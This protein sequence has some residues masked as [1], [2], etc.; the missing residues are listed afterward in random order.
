MIRN[1]VSNALP[2]LFVRN[3]KDNKEEELIFCD[4]KVYSPGV[5]EM[6]KDRNTDNV[7]ISYS[8][9]KTN[10]KTYIYNVKTKEKKLVK[11]QIIPSGHDPENY[12]T[13]RLECKSHDGRL[14]PLTITRHKKTKLD[15][16]ANVLL[17]GYSSYGSTNSNSF[18]NL[19]FGMELL[20]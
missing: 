9:P 12:I 8:S 11:E 7:Y 14:I 16:S 13:E 20:V 5:A 6:Q 18:S 10:A 17:Y 19:F 2:K 1:E 4:V 3:L 15:G